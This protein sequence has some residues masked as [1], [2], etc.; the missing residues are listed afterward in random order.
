MRQS[1]VK[2]TG[3]NPNTKNKSTKQNARELKRKKKREERKEARI[4][5]KQDK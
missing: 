3:S 2:L 4:K 5:T 1:E